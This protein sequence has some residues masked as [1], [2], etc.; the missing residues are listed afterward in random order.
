MDAKRFLQVGLMT[1][2]FGAGYLLGGAKTAALV[3]EAS[4][5]PIPVVQAN[6]VYE[7]RT[8]TANPGKLDDLLA[9]F[10]DHTTGL[11][12]KH[13]IDNLAYWT[14][15]D[16]PESGNTL[17]YLIHHANR[18]QADANWTAFGSDPQWRKV[19]QKSQVDGKFLARPPDRLYLKALD[20]SPVL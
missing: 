5:S 12:N 20:F 16:E 14:P 4:A 11:F 19:A 9:R 15:F 1:T 6:M 2:L 3:S 18:K 13:G 7:L 10:R 8:Y 17:I